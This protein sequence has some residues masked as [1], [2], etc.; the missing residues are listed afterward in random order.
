MNRQ[1]NRSGS[2]ARNTGKPG[3]PPKKTGSA[4]TGKRVGK[5]RPVVKEEPKKE[6]A[7]RK[8]EKKP[9]ARKTQA[10]KPVK[11]PKDRTLS[12]E[13]MRLNRYIANSGVCSRREADTYITAGVVT[14]NGKVVTELGTRVIPGDEVRFDGRLLSAE[15]KVYLLLNKPKDFVTTTED[16][17]AE[18]TVM[19]LVRNACDERIYPVGRLD[20]NTTGLLLFTNDGDL[21]KKLTH[22]SHNMKKVYQVSLDKP[23]TKSDMERVADGFELEDGFIAADAI[24]YI[25]AEAKTEIGIEIHSGKNRIVRRIFEHLGYRVKKLDRVLFAGLTKKNLPRGKWR[26]LTDNE[27]KF[28]KMN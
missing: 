19:E 13:G 9:F 12:S 24:S 2:S 27:V 25:D 1:N 15:K 3:R 14:I 18:R 8:W 7:P 23:L 21:S 11:Q 22:P 5:S 10:E 16:P 17:H 6:F 28:L 20:R 4:P 26:F